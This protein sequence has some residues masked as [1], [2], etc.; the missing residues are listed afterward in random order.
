M[1]MVSPGRWSLVQ[2]SKASVPASYS[3]IAP[4]VSSGVEA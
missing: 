3:A 4:K 1:E 2:N